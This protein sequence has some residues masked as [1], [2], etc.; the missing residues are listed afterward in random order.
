MTD[1]NCY[2]KKKEYSTKKKITR[3][4][5]FENSLQINN[6]LLSILNERKS[7]EESFYTE[8]IEFLKYK[9]VYY[10][11]KIDLMQDLVNTVR[12]IKTILENR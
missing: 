2:N 10:E 9:K 5:R 3:K 4:N 1:D 6:N 8:K 7:T 11:K 12:D